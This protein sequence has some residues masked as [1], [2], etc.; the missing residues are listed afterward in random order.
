MTAGGLGDGGRVTSG[1]TEARRGDVLPPAGRC[2][3]RPDH[4]AALAA[5]SHASASCA[6]MPLLPLA[7]M[8]AGSALASEFSRAHPGNALAAGSPLASWRS[9]GWT[10]AEDDVGGEG[11]ELDAEIP[12]RGTAAVTYLRAT[13]RLSQTSLTSSLPWST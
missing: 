11:D 1:E 2:V 8:T 5:I 12:R 9:R 6:Q 7:S 4:D 13:R 10:A 3:S